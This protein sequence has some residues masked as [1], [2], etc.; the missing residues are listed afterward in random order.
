[1]TNTTPIQDISQCPNCLCM[2][3]T[4]KGKCGKCKEI[5][6][7][8]IQ[9]TEKNLDKCVHEYRQLVPPINTN[10]FNGGGSTN[11]KF[12]CIKCLDIKII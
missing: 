11:T 8:P 1:M 3:K 4:V 2:T 10:S 12:Y 5:K 7:T 6:S 9:E